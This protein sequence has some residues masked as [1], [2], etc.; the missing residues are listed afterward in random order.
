LLLGLTHCD[1]ARHQAATDA[2]FKVLPHAN[3]DPVR[4]GLNRLR[5][6]GFGPMPAFF[7]IAHDMP[8][9]VHAATLALKSLILS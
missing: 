6:R 4:T 5:P 7:Q 3:A 8:N 9:W 2:I 1:P